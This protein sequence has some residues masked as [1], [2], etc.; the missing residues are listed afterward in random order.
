[1]FTKLICVPGRGATTN[2]DVELDL[3]I[4]FKDLLC[5]Y[6]TRKF[7]VQ[8]NREELIVSVDSVALFRSSINRNLLIFSVDLV[9]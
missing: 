8:I 6:T 5:D 4:E 2:Q 1:M 3:F 7:S 9:K